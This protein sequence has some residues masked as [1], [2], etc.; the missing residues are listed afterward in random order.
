MLEDVQAIAA[1]TNK[2][3][4]C[5]HETIENYHYYS[6]NPI[7]QKVVDMHSRQ[8]AGDHQGEFSS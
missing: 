8:V 7:Q 1:I 6:Y 5:L 3:N 2:T 4:D